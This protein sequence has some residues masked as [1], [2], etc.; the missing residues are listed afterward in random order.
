M[1]ARN[2]KVYSITFFCWIN[3]GLVPQISS[4]S[5]LHSVTGSITDVLHTGFLAASKDGDYS[6]H[7]YLKSQMQDLSWLN[8][9]LSV[10]YIILFLTT[11]L[12]R[13]AA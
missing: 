9:A 12:Y 8:F 10:N 7:N 11:Y 6:A 5:L 1:R 2:N 13:S 3:F 4:I